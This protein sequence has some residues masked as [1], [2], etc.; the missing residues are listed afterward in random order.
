MNIRANEAVEKIKEETDGRLVIQIFPSSQLGSDTD[1]L[2]QVRSG[3]VEF[4]TLS[5]L[6]L[7]TLVPNASLSTASA[8]PSPTMPPS[9]RRWTASSAPMCAAR[10]ARPTSSSMDKI[11]DNGFRQITSLQGADQHRPT[12]SRASRSACRSARSG[13]RCSPPSSRHRPSINFA[14][15]YTALQTKIVDGQENPLAI[16]STAKLFEVQKYCSMTNHMWDGFW[17]LGNRRAWER[18]PEDLR[19]IVAK[20]LNEAALLQR[21]DV[22]KLNA[23]LRGDLDRQGHGLQRHPGRALPGGAAQGRLL[24]RV[25]EEVW[26]R[27]LG[28]PREGRRQLAELIDLDTQRQLTRLN[29]DRAD[30]GFPTRVA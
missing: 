13:P 15:V 20:N 6:I 1:M 10:S 18:L 16:I 2:S 7:S 17:F 14:E 21:D 27:G 8:S 5:P 24:R 25:E 26:R 30:A 19:A 29:R 23:G 4:F 28:H 3:G 12:I 9:G 11:W 22:E